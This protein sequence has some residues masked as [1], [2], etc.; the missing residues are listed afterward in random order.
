MRVPTPKPLQTAD[1]VLGGVT[2]LA[3]VLGVHFGIDLTEDAPWSEWLFSPD[4]I[5]SDLCD[6]GNRSLLVPALSQREARALGRED[7]E[8]VRASAKVLGTAAKEALQALVELAEGSV[9]A[10]PRLRA[11]LC[12]AVREELAALLSEWKAVQPEEVTR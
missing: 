6:P 10:T 12:V 5:L 11:R 9:V 1:G 7:V 2:P 4:A 3:D 8:G